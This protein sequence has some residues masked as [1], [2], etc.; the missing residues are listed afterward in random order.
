M[1]LTLDTSFVLLK[2]PNV[3]KWF[4]IASTQCQQKLDGILENKLELLQEDIFFLVHLFARVIAKTKPTFII[5][6]LR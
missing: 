1:C 4:L 3:A 6:V 5:S 2:N